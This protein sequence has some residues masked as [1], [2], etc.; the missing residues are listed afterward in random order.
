MAPH[1]DPTVSVAMDGIESTPLSS[2]S[3][4]PTGSV[5]MEGDSS[6]GVCKAWS[7]LILGAHVFPNAELARYKELDMDLHPRRSPDCIAVG[8]AASKAASTCIQVARDLPPR[9]CRYVFRSADRKFCVDL[10][11]YWLEHQLDSAC[12]L[13]L[14]S[15]I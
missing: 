12:L 6:S 13:F 11:F 8:F 15:T 5:A 14:M 4:T 9:I 7:Q 1:G 3:A 10:L 2:R